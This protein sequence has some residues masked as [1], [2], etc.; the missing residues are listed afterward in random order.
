MW[1][2]RKHPLLKAIDLPMFVAAALTVVFYVVISREAFND[3]KIQHYTSEHVVEYVVVAFFI[4]AAV[5]VGP[6][7]DAQGGGNVSKAADSVSD[8]VDT[9]NEALENSPVGEAIEKMDNARSQ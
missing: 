1:R 3:T 5:V 8:A 2:A 6:T 4:Y 7:Q 9:V